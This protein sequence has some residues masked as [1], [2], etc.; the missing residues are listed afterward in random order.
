VADAV[1][2]ELQVL[3]EPLLLLDC[4]TIGGSN[5]VFRFA[6]YEIIWATLK[7]EAQ[8]IRIISALLSCGS[9][10]LVI[11]DSAGLSA[12]SSIAPN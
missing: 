2:A 8:L 7:F 9:P 1:I 5:Y 10:A 3:L 6:A 4:D 11:L 12:T